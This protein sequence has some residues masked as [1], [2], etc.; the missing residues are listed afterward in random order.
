MLGSFV[1]IVKDPLKA[2]YVLLQHLFLL[3]LSLR[4]T[5]IK[6]DFFVII[7]SFCSYRISLVQ[8]DKVIHKFKI[9][10]SI[11]INNLLLYLDLVIY[12][13]IL[14]TVWNRINIDFTFIHLTHS[15]IIY[16]VYLHI[17]EVFF[18]NTGY[19]ISQSFN[20]LLILNELLITLRSLNILLVSDLLI[21]NHQ[22]LS[23]LF[24]PMGQ[25]LAYLVIIIKSFQE[26]IL[27]DMLVTI[28]RSHMHNL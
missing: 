19:N 26:K 23:Y 13:L 18:L 9:S 14:F 25:T 20:L 12:L 3:S 28:L 2:F 6:L 24:L 22:L 1:I 11:L 16:I 10:L 27:L 5:H 21:L 4:S 8:F 7:H 17:R 15:I